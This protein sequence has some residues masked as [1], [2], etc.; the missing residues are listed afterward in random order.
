MGFTKVIYRID[1]IFLKVRKSLAKLGNIHRR[2]MLERIVWRMYKDG[3][4][5]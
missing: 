3:C 1:S 2:Q 5:M 4:A